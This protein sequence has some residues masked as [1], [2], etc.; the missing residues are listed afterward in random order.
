[1]RWSRGT[2]S[3]NLSPAQPMTGARAGVSVSVTGVHDPVH[4][5][6]ARR[7][8]H[9]PSRTTQTAAAYQRR[10]VRLVLPLWRSFRHT[11]RARSG[12]SDIGRC[13]TRQR[14]STNG[15]RW[16]P[17]TSPVCAD[18]DVIVAGTRPGIS[19]SSHPSQKIAAMVPPSGRLRR[20]PRVASTVL[21][22]AL[23]A[24]IFLTV[25]WYRFTAGQRGC[26]AE[27]RTCGQRSIIK[28]LPL[29]GDSHHNRKLPLSSRT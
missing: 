19:L 1:M 17:S 26:P 23:V 20:R 29:R 9:P 14:P 21:I 6:H 7:R 3:H 22:C 13:R 8:C 16:A 4:R 18:A 10:P 5:R 27:G 15:E 2:D 24:V 28:T 25:H 12:S 11:L